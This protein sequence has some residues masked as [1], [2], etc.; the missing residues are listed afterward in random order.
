MSVK[1]TGKAQGDYVVARASNNRKSIY[2]QAYQEIKDQYQTS[3]GKGLDVAGKLALQK[4]IERWFHV[5]CQKRRRDAKIER[6]KELWNTAK[7]VGKPFHYY[8]RAVSELFGALPSEMVAE[9]DTK[10]IRYSEMGP[11]MD[12]RLHNGEHNTEQR[13]MALTEDLY[14]HN[15]VRIV[16]FTAYKTS[17][18]GIVTQMVDF[19]DRFGE[20]GSTMEKVVGADA[21]AET[22][23]ADLFD[24]FCEVMYTTS[25]AKLEATKK[26]VVRKREMGRVTMNLDGGGAPVLPNPS[27]SKLPLG[28]SSMRKYQAKL[29]RTFTSL[30]YG[31]AQGVPVTTGGT[32]PTIPWGDFAQR[33]QEYVAAE[34]L[35]DW[36]LQDLKD[37]GIMKMG[38][39]QKLLLF[40]Y[41]RQQDEDIAL[42][43][44]HFK[45]PGAST[46]MLPSKPSLNIQLNVNAEDE[47]TEEG[48]GEGEMDGQ[49][50]TRPPKKV[51][52]HVRM[53][54]KENIDDWEDIDS[55]GDN[56]DVDLNNPQQIAK[57]KGS[58][59][60]KGK[61]TGKGRGKGEGSSARQE[62]DASEDLAS[63]NN[64]E[65][66]RYPP[67]PYAPWPIL[68]VAV[69][70]N[71]TPSTKK[72]STKSKEVQPPKDAT[73][74]GDNEGAFEKLRD[75]LEPTSSLR[76]L[77]DGQLNLHDDSFTE[78]MVLEEAALAD[79]LLQP[80]D[81]DSENSSQILSSVDWSGS[82]GANSGVRNT[83]ASPTDTGSSKPPVFAR[84]QTAKRGAGWKKSM[85]SRCDQQEGHNGSELATKG[86][87]SGPA[88]SE[89]PKKVLHVAETATK[90]VCGSKQRISQVS[91]PESPT[92]NP[93]SVTEAP[94][95]PE[96]Q[97]IAELPAVAL[98]TRSVTRARDLEAQVTEG[99]TKPPNS[100]RRSARLGR[101]D[102]PTPSASETTDV[103]LKVRVR[104]KALKKKPSAAVPNATNV[105][106]FFDLSKEK[107][108]GRATEG[109]P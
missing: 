50:V 18:G 106:E 65:I 53:V 40:W 76:P 90:H 61:R 12:I 4:S 26:A 100:S 60:A 86:S 54:E 38:A 41:R 32:L 43:F 17:T 103:P 69:Q 11:P 5:N 88:M 10:A 20:S 47:A 82:E 98:S 80:N 109:K 81:S 13:M 23:F 84:K 21:I 9:Y 45:A 52:I 93:A 58:A 27:P 74:V 55:G 15:F 95:A 56:S 59:K 97:P 99:M 28:E 25:P 87:D 67:P 72:R 102:H 71:T 36:A 6:A 101:K 63:S 24:D 16:A 105:D 96:V 107:G 8:Q 33:P 1:R 22:G 2:R 34:Y 51:T 48:L 104:P 57:G 19:N 68:K 7:Q 49:V 73:R 70:G 92:D 79:E 75:S 44:H 64:T 83:S 91:D 37:P 94:A 42:Q 30:N 89:V 77:D 85:P 35:P 14:K 3:H 39:V 108:K 78:G 66:V 29:L 62:N 31:R 46:T